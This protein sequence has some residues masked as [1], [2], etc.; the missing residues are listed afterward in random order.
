M[1]RKALP[2]LEARRLK[3]YSELLVAATLLLLGQPG[4]LRA[5]AMLQLFNLSWN[6]VA[7]KIPEIAEAG[8]SS[9]WLPPPTKGG[10][11][12]SVGYDLFDPFDLGDKDQRGTVGTRYGTRE[13]LLRLVRLAHRF[14]LRVYFDNIVNHRGFEVPGY[15]ANTPTNLYPGMVPG[16]FHLMTISGGF[17][18]NASNIRDYNSQWQ[19]QNLSLSGLIDIAHENPN[20]NFGPSEGS[21][22]SKPVL[23]R[24]PNNPEYYDFNSAGTR[25]GFGNVTQADVSANPNAFKEDVGGYLLRSVRWLMDQTKCDGLRLDAVKHVPSYFF[26]QQNGAGKDSDSSGYVGNAQLQFNLAHGITDSNH[27]D[28]N[29]D[30]EAPRTDALIFGEHLGEPPTFGEY[31]D[32]GMRLLD[33]PLRNNLNNIL[34]NPGATLAG[35]EQRDGGGFAANVRVMHAQSHDND[36]AAH[37][38]LQNAYYFMREGVPLIYS[39]GYHQASGNPPFPRHANA[40]YLGEF[41]DNKMP[42]L[43]YL[44]H[45]LARGGTRARWG[46]SDTIAFERYDYR[47]AANAIDQTVVLFAMNDNYGNPGDISFDD[48][49]AQSDDGMPSTCYPVVNSRGQG[50]VVGFPPGSHLRQ[51]ADSPSKDRACAEVLVRL[52]TNDKTEAQNS[53]NDPNPVNR[54]I[55]VGSQTLVAGGGAIEIKIP[56]G[57]YVLYG[58]QW[59]EPSRVDATLTNWDGVVTNTDAVVIQ[60]NGRA[61]PRMLIY[62]TDGPDG[63][64]GFNP[65]YPFKMRGSVDVGGNVAGGLNVSNRTYAIS[66]PVVTN[67][68]PLDF[69]ARV[70]GSAA[71]ASLKLDGGVDLNSQ[72]GGLGASNTFTSGLLDLRDNK[73]GTAY[74]MLLGYEQCATSFRYGP[75]KFAARNTTRNTVRSLGAETYIYTVGSDTTTNIV[76]GSGLGAD[77]PEQTAAWVYHDASASNNVAGQTVVR[78]RSS[79]LSSTAV[80]LWV[81]VGYQFNIS[82]CSIYYTTDGTNPEGAYGVGQG[83]TRAV[84]ATFAGDDASDGTIDWWKGTIPAQPSGFTVKY[85]IAL[86]KNNAGP[87]PDYADSKHYALTQFAITNWNPATAQVWLHNDL[88]TNQIVTG[89]AE[90]F[91]ILRARAFLPRTNKSSV[92]NTFS[93]SFYY[94]AQPPDGIIAFPGADGAVV[95]SVDYDFVVRADETATEVEYNITDGDPNN[96]DAA[97]GFSNG[98]GLRNGQPVFG[99]ATRVAPSAS[100]SQQFPNFPQEFRFTYFAVPSNGTA[101]IRIRLKE[102]TTATF[103]NHYREVT[104]AISAAAPPQTISI[105]FPSV[106]GQSISLSQSNVYT[107]VACFTDTLT[108]D[109]NLFTIKIDGADQPRTNANGTA[110]YR[111]QGSYCGAGRKDLRYDWSG[112]NSG[113]HYI[114]ILY[115]GD[116]LN[117]QASRLVQV[118]ISGETDSDGDG[119]PDNWERQYG[120]NPLD[121]AG[122]NGAAGDPD[123]DGFTNLQEYLAGTDPKDPASLLRLTQLSGGGQIIT[124]TSVPGRNYQVLAAAGF[125]SAFSPVSG[126]ITAFGGTTSF[127]NPAPASARQFYRVQLAP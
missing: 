83:T 96:D 38:E 71:S 103:T 78:Q 42:D 115:N 10:S 5:D 55:Y 89:L 124:W 86:Y 99:K 51:L 92:F 15:D 119:L 81:K 94:D 105:A 46:D 40:P 48:G 72:M 66:V 39:D 118:S 95:Q 7:D 33:A 97:T 106:N 43:A 120:L 112:M 14:G 56:S 64:A 8:Y 73:P 20:A 79:T 45:Q 53:I 50:F 98:N 75:E 59:P 30:P 104:R 87:I 26:G 9:L 11:G 93:Q 24:H 4:E 21:T 108:A 114:Q 57:S 36:Y 69:L 68:G 70:D 88:A 3:S 1:F 65:S 47:E 61:V 22:A 17:F 85:K 77:Y 111:V 12:Y 91:H 34:G 58:Y 31:V 121:G 90:G 13:E 29:F 23:V 109:V 122:A 62:R 41:G 32:A 110:A 100:L 52:A 60:Q 28:S 80:D 123:G 16:D 27:R 113:Q 127:T 6:E 101:T 35:L 84:A 82:K 126:T 37:R 117:L 116:G 2:L 49:V 102:F 107:I 67:A 18:R 25:V 44:H 76:T 54:K 74:D 63:D 19:V 125:G